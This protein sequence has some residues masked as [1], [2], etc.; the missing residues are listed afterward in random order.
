MMTLA[1]LFAADSAGNA[2]ENKFPDRVELVVPLAAGGGVDALARML[3][4]FLEK[5][6]PGNPQVDVV[7]RP[8]GGS[9]LGANWFETNAKPDGATVLVTSS[10]TMNPYI[11]G[12]DGVEFNLANKRLA[13]AYPSGM[14]V[15]GAKGLGIEKPED[16]GSAKGLIFGGISAAGSDLAA[17]LAFELLGLDYKAVMGF[18][19]RGPVRL[20]F[21]RGETNLDFQVTS[22][23]L[24]Q[25]APL[26][27][28]G[29]IAK[30]MSQGVRA[31]DG[32]LSARDPVLSD[33]PSLYEL[34]VSMK[35][36]APSGP[37]WD[38]Y[39]VTAVLSFS[40]GMTA[41]LH[42]DTP[43][44]IVNAFDAAAEAIN[45]D[46]DF[47]TASRNLSGGYSLLSGAEAEKALHEA[48]A[49]DAEAVTYIKDLLSSK[50]NVRF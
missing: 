32:T 6:L 2:Q 26:A 48:L 22:A 44:Q 4:P 31:A 9:L 8:G 34:Y 33:F 39:E 41:F 36:Q 14:A 35:G 1:A 12:Q 28:S 45:A 13:F 18:T 20:A 24:T 50:F 25:T 47:V 15:Y 3:E 29:R 43:D 11:L 23:Y 30:I 10:S 16:I 46:P 38:A 27:V 37:A 7:N 42:E 5:Y 17:L 19:G 21:E 49:P 40:I